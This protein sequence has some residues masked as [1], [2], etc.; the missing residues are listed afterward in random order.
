MYV[1]YNESEARLEL[2]LADPEGV[3][4]LLDYFVRGKQSGKLRKKHKVPVLA[5]KP[6]VSRRRKSIRS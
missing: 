1:V 5:G 4:D 6:A 2:L 3:L